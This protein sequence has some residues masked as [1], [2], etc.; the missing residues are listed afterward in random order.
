MSPPGIDELLQREIDG[1]NTAST[2]S[3]SA[4]ASSPA[5]KKMPRRSAPR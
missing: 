3:P 2:R 1:V 5:R 4:T